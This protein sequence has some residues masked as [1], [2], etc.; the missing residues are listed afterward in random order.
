MMLEHVQ[1]VAML[2]AVV[3]GWATIHV[4]R[5]MTFQGVGLQDGGGYA[6]LLIVTLSINLAA[7]TLAI[8]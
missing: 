7:V 6:A 3:S 2:V 5:A 8:S 4:A 1:L